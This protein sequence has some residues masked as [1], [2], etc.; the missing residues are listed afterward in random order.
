MINLMINL[1][2]KV[3]QLVEFEKFDLNAFLVTLEDA[4]KFA[5]VTGSC[6]CLT[7]QSLK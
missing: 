6:S 4:T 7:D 2:T 3:E 1:T 5:G